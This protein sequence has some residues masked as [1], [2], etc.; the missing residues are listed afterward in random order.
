MSSALLQDIIALDDSFHE[1]G[2]MT[3]D[4]LTFMAELGERRAFS[5][6][7]E[8]GCGKS[9]LLLSNLG[10]R[11]T[12]FTLSHYGEIPCESYSVVSRSPLLNSATTEFVCGPS[13]VTLPRHDFHTDLQLALIDGPHAFPFPQLEYFYLYRRIERGGFLVVDDHSIPSV[14]LLIR[15]L[16]DDEMFEFIRQV[17]DTVFFRRT[18]APLFNPFGDEWETQGYNIRRRRSQNGFVRTIRNHLARF[19]RRSDP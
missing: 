18:D 5:D 9:T 4:V 3:P 8:T 14:E 15:F 16:L 19:R 1:A 12:V 13:Q 10:T 7:A 2:V 17:D 11:H 6:T